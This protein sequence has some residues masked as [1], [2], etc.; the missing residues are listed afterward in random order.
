MADER[1][2]M[3]QEQPYVAWKGPG[4]TS[5]VPSVPPSWSRPS[6][7]GPRPAYE[8]PLDAPYPPSGSAP[9][10]VEQP[11]YSASG[12][13]PLKIWRKR[14]APTN[15]SGGGRAGIGMPDDRPNGAVLQTGWA[16]KTPPQLKETPCC[17][18]ANPDGGYNGRTAM[19]PTNIDPLQGRFPKPNPLTDSFLDAD[20]QAAC[21]ACNPQN[22]VIRRATTVLSKKYYTDSRAYLKARG[23]RYDQNLGTGSRIQGTRY[24]DASRP[25]QPDVLWPSNNPSIGPPRY[26][27]ADCACD[28]S[29]AL[30]KDDNSRNEIWEGF[31]ADQRRQV[32]LLIQQGWAPGA[33][34][35]QIHAL[36]SKQ[37]TRGKTLIYKPNNRKFGVQGAV[38]SST[39]LD[40]LKLD[41]IT[42]AAA[43]QK[44][45]WGTADAQAARYTGRAQSP[46]RLKSKYYRCSGG[47]CF[48]PR[49]APRRA[50]ST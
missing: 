9:R 42:N 4:T 44:A 20:G 37:P 26:R 30:P 19:A 29:R 6:A 46:Y 31:G 18:G 27:T 28:P 12:S 17:G 11:R 13:R 8:P 50:A 40:R 2:Y 22:H 34:L 35:D 47:S 3:W 21:V 10:Y 14:V 5:A 24:L 15:S 7:N 23:R 38:Q 39:R 1:T 49:L 36:A 45:D 33:A 32:Q 25:G 43:S 48:H 16:G 41:T